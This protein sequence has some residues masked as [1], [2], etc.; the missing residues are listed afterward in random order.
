M[1]EERVNSSEMKACNKTETPTEEGVLNEKK[2]V[3]G[4][5]EVVQE[6]T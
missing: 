1:E 6:D 4:N 2:E 5:L 3:G